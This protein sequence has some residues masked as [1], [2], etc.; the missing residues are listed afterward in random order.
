MLKALYQ[1]WFKLR[2][3]R[4]LLYCSLVL[5]VLMLYATFPTANL[6]KEVVAQGFGL[7]QWDIIIMIAVSSDLIAVEFR[8]HTITTLLYKS[9][10]RLI[11]YLAKFVISLLVS[12]LLLAVG[13]VLTLLFKL[14]F[15]TKFTWSQPLF[16]HSLWVNFLANLG[17]S[18]VYLVFIITLGMLLVVLFHSNA[19]TIVAGLAIGFLGAPMSALL[20]HALPGIKAVIAWNP[21]NMIN[22]IMPLANSSQFIFLSEGQLIIGNLVYSALFLL[23]GLWAFGRSNV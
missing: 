2:Q 20:I 6:T 7:T 17:G 21:L 10:S 19:L 18:L 16:H 22:V 23:V 9:E 3:R 5:L 1:E 4:L 11:P 12:I 14:L 13:T 15:A 8:D